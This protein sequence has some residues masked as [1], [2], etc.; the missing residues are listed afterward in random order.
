MDG[1]GVMVGGAVGAVVAVAGG[2]VGCVTVVCGGWG[3]CSMGFNISGV[4]L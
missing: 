2:G 4:N 3:V 1:A